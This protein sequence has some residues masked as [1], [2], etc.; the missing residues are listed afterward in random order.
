LPSWP[1]ANPG[2]SSISRN[3]S[4]ET[5]LLISACE[6]P[7][8]TMAMS[9]APEP[10]SVRW[11]PFAIARNDSSTT[12]TSATAITVDSESHR[13]CGRLLRLMTVTATICRSNE[14]MFSLVPARRRSSAAW[15]SRPG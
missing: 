14:R 7:R 4:R 6:P 8:S 3:W 12:T 15:R 5:V 1:R 2:P 11:N 9:C 10:A 13:R